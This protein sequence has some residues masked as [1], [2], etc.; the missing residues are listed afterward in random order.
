VRDVLADVEAS[1]SV[2]MNSVTDNPL[3]FPRRD[4][5]TSGDLRRQLPRRADG[6]RRRRLAIALAELGSI[7]ER[8]IEKLTNA[9]VLGAAAFLVRTP[10]STRAS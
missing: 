5:E 6:D 9:G 3:V 1:G 10:G 8:R 4:R 2:E 7:S